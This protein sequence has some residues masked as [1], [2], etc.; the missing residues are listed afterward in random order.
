MKNRWFSCKDNNY[1]QQK[2]NIDKSEHV[3][4]ILDGYDL[5]ACLSKFWDFSYWN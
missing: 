1:V 4:L 5:D 2:E 3:K